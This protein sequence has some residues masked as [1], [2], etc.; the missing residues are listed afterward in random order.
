MELSWKQEQ[1]ERFLRAMQS[2]GKKP[3]LKLLN[4]ELE[5]LFYEMDAVKLSLKL[6]QN[7]NLEITKE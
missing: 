5:V 1:I 7:I 3:R 6:S 4:Q 2:D